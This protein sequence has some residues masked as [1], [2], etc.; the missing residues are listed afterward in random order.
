MSDPRWCCQPSRGSRPSD[1]GRAH[2]AASDRLVG[3]ACPTAL[4]FVDPELVVE[5]REMLLDGGLGD[6]ELAR[7][8]PRG[9]RLTE[10]I[11]R[12]HRAAERDEHLPLPSGEGGTRLSPNRLLAWG[13]GFVQAHDE[14][15]G[16]DP[17]LVPRIGA[18]AVPR[19]ARRSRKFRSV[20]KDRERTNAR[21]HARGRNGPARPF[22]RTA[23]GGRSSMTDRS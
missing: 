10:D 17:D 21:R 13:A 16:S 19:S 12:E 6:H 14:S 22:D 7:D 4:L 20:R 5:P 15:H 9:G 3:E 23:R 2:G 8:L 18:G 11:P 1:L